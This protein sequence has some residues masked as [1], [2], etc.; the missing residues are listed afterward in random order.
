MN[1]EQF[2]FYFQVIQQR[3]AALPKENVQA[4]QKIETALEN[5]QI[6]YEQ[7]QT[8]LEAAELVQEGALQH[9]QQLADRHQHYYELFQSAPIAFLITNT[10]G[11]ILEA[12]AAI[13]ELLQVPQPYLVGRPLVLYVAESDRSAFRAQLNQS[14][15]TS[16]AAPGETN[17]DQTWQINLRCRN[18]Q[19]LPS[20]W[21]VAIVRN[22]VGAVESLRIGVY[23]LAPPSDW[24]EAVTQLAGQASS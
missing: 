12:N 23:K 5:L 19:L 13:A 10:D 6:I 17:R 1:N 3:I 21:Q 14:C 18:G 8:L 4:W 15:N 9:N 16:C 11:V 20:K 7:M 22:A 2:S 24:V